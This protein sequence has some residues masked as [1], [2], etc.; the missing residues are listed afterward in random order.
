MIQNDVTGLLNPLA[1]AVSSPHMQKLNENESKPTVGLG[2][3]FAYG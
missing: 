3:D 2:R 1:S